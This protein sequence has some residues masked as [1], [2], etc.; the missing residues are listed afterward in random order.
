MFEI[1][2]RIKVQ[3][4]RLNSLRLGSTNLIYTYSISVFNAP[5]FFGEKIKSYFIT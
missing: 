3:S 4:R 1:F 2:A 5:L